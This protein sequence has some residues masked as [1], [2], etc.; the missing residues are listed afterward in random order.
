MICYNMRKILLFGVLSFLTSGVY[1]E[2][3]LKS[4]VEKDGA[5]EVVMEDPVAGDNVMVTSAILVNGGKNVYA[6]MLVCGLSDGVGTYTL[7]F[8]MQKSFVSPGVR[9][10]INGEESFTDISVEASGIAGCSAE[11]EDSSEESGCSC[12]CGC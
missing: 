8:P 6:T 11:S 3:G 7:T 10:V 2:V 5:L 4:I 1:A 12:G 9:M